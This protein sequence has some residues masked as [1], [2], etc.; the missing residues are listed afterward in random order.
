MILLGVDPGASGAICLTDG[1]HHDF[2]LLSET[3]ADIACLLGELDGHDC[4]AFLERVHSM[5]AQ[6]VASS[7][8]FGQ[9]YGFL[10]GLLVAFKIPFEEVT[11]QR[12]QRALG[13]LTGGDKRISKAKA[14]S[15][16]PQIKFTHATA[17]SA[18]IAEYG[19][20]LRAGELK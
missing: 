3:E 16:F 20:R 14:Q 15:L 18:L 12:W 17:D 11:P 5:P 13:C 4:H 2:I 9:N 7:F 19:R 10:R 1:T 6:G 8:K